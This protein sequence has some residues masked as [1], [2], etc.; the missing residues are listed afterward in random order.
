[1]AYPY[2]MKQDKYPNLLFPMIQYW[3]EVLAEACEAN[4]NEAAE[5]AKSKL[6]YFCDRHAN[7]QA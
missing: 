1:M 6:D 2:S 5:Y 7:L 3:A 4:D